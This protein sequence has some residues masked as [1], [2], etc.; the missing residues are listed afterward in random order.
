MRSVLYL[1]TTTVIILAPITSFAQPTENYFPDIPFLNGYSPA[2]QALADPLKPR[3]N[4][5][6]EAYRLLARTRRSWDA[7]TSDWISRDSSTYTYTET[8]KPD[9]ITDYESMDGVSWVLA[10]RNRYIYDANDNQAMLI[11]ESWDGAQWVPGPIKISWE[12]DAG[13]KL[14]MTVLEFW[15]GSSY[16]NS[17]RTNLVYDPQT[18]LLSSITHQFWD[19][20]TWADDNRDLYDPY[21]ANGS[22]LLVTR[23]RWDNV[24]LAWVTESRI[25]HEYDE[26]GNRVMELYEITDGVEWIG[27]H[28]LLMAYDTNG[29]ITSITNQD[30]NTQTELWENVNLSVYEYDGSGF[31][32]TRL[33]YTWDHSSG[34]W[35]NLSRIS[36]QNDE[37]G[38]PLI[39]ESQRWNLPTASWENINQ[40]IF[41]YELFVGTEEPAGAP[42]EA[43]VELYPNPSDGAFFIRL[44]E[45]YFE[46]G[47][48]Q[49]NIVNAYG[50]TVRLLKF[51]STAQPQPIDLQ[52]LPQGLYYLYFVQ[53]KTMISK[54]ISIAKH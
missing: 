18:G 49:L 31:I 30:W 25:T 7:F 52:G 53:G 16:N 41:Y 4:S 51:S 11:F 37:Q 32:I 34:S 23:Q 47:P 50:Q 9:V 35:E 38:N 12:Y 44:N 29:S 28:R 26:G 6:S 22:I 14:I 1:L 5:I 46:A 42:D 27:D 43:I 24:L 39:V 8:D 2:G 45:Q 19:A 21:D 20:I 10:D 40:E 54:S 13:G 33:F 17:F 3:L 15:N 36:Y 48:L